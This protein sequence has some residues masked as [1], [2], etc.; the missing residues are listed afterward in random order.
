MLE[1]TIS[2]DCAWQ[3]HG[4]ALTVLLKAYDRPH[5]GSVRLLCSCTLE[6]TEEYA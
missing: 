2:R 6:M 5:S 3:T 4:G 1:M